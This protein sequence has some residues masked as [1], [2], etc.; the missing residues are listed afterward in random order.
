MCNNYFGL[1]VFFKMPTHC[2][3]PS[4]PPIRSY[5]RDLLRHLAEVQEANNMSDQSQCQVSEQ[6]VVAFTSMLIFNSSPGASFEKRCADDER[7]EEKFWFEKLINTKFDV[8][9]FLFAFSIFWGVEKASA[10]KI[11]CWMKIFKVEYF[12]KAFLQ[13]DSS[14]GIVHC[15]WSF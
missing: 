6:N 10:N 7:G 1:I 13:N 8:C 4:P 9:K 14:Y 11:K 3:T 12:L 15:R 2:R 5:Q